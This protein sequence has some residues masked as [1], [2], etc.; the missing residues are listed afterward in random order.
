MATNCCHIRFECFIT[1]IICLVNGLCVC[2]LYTRGLFSITHRFCPVFIDGL[3]SLLFTLPVPIHSRHT[4]L[5]CYHIYFPFLAFI[6]VNAFHSKFCFKPFHQR[7][8]LRTFCAA[9]TTFFGGDMRRFM[10]VC[11]CLSSHFAHHSE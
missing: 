2:A 1:V 7:T 9:C 4:K 10:V 8:Y 11:L 5:V 6:L 3:C